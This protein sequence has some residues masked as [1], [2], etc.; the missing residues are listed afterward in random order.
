M[1]RILFEKS[2]S[3][4]R[5]IG[6]YFGKFL[7]IPVESSDYVNVIIELAGSFGLGNLVKDIHLSGLLT[8]LTPTQQ[9]TFFS[10]LQ[11]WISEWIQK[12]PVPLQP[13]SLLFSLVSV[14]LKSLSS[15]ISQDWKALLE[16]IQST[17]H[18]LAV[19]ACALKQVCRDT[20]LE[21]TF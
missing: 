14:Y 11:N 5:S 16:T 8:S 6:R 12:D 20:T 19:M 21:L 4:A 7:L 1:A 10:C 18:S 13:L 17:P 9:A 15:D 3:L 2:L